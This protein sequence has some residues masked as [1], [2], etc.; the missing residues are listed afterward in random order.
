MKPPHISVG[1]RF[2]RF[3][4]AKDWAGV[5][6]VIDPAID[7]R[8]L[9]PG[10]P[11]EATSAK[12]L[13]ESVFQVWFEPSDDIYEIVAIAGDHI[14]NRNRIVYRF[15]VRNRGG[16]HVCEQTAY[17]DVTRDKIVKLRILCSGFL[18]PAEHDRR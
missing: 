2:V 4:L 16:D 18:K 13:I 14:S 8:G 6:D 17:Y 5:E 9:T 1:D 12:S 7:F 11:W 15:R 3:L 10:S